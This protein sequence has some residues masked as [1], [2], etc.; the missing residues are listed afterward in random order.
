MT[1]FIFRVGKIKSGYVHSVP[2]QLLKGCCNGTCCRL[3]RRESIMAGNLFTINFLDYIF[4]NYT[5]FFIYAN[6]FFKSCG[7]FRS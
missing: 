4:C 3:S 5:T 6:G 7:L 1:V 2:S